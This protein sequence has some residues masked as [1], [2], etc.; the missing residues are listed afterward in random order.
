MVEHPDQ[1]EVT[2]ALQNAV[3]RVM[4][5]TGNLRTWDQGDPSEPVTVVQAMT[6]AL[7]GLKKLEGRRSSA[8]PAEVQVLA[9]D[10]P[11]PIG[12]GDVLTMRF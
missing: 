3:P 1:P 4:S 7:W 12:A 5:K 10:D 9:N 11:L 6:W 8:P 2:I